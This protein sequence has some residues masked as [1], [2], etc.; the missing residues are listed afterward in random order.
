MEYEILSALNESHKVY[1]VCDKADGKV[2]VQKEL[3]T[4][5]A[6]VYATLAQ[7]PVQ[8]IPRIINIAED[9]SKGILTIIEEYISGNTLDDLIE[10]DGALPEETVISYILAL[11]GILKQLHGFNPPIIHRDITP[12][13]VMLAGDGRLVLL[14][15]N[16][17]KFAEK[18]QSKDTRLLG[19]PGYAAPEQLGFGASAVTTD[20]YAL[21]MLMKALLT[22]DTVLSTPYN[23]YLAP[24][25]R[26]CTDLKPQKRYRNVSLLMKALNRAE[27]LHKNRIWLISGAALIVLAVSVITV[28]FITKQL[29]SLPPQQWDSE[30]IVTPEIDSATEELIIG[31]YKG[32][33]DGGL[34]INP[35]GSAIYYCPSRQYSEVLCPWTFHDNTVTIKLSKLHC[36]ISAEIDENAPGRLNFTSDSRNWNDELFEKLDDPSFSYENMALFAYDDNLLIAEDGGYEFS[37]GSF[38]FHIPRHYTDFPDFTDSDK[39]RYIFIDANADEAYGSQLY[40]FHDDSFDDADLMDDFFQGYA[41]SFAMDFID[42]INITDIKSR[43][44][45]PATLYSCHF[46]G[47]YNKGFNG[48]A[49]SPAAGTIV[50]MYNS[51]TEGVVKIIFSQ[52]SDKNTDLTAEFDDIISNANV[53]KTVQE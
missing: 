28:Y 51:D 23:G 17:G 32:S 25:I 20:I 52:I 9:R 34:T 21:G 44:Q 38:S 40:F 7:Y 12:G 19:T 15:L 10:T 13:N 8:G 33:D 6:S 1:L 30:E 45:G 49:G 4:Y 29:G 48:M 42:S 11:C 31:S 18:G 39:E 24:V 35:D 50:F 5:N 43:T 47:I 2:Y 26:K 27:R 37:V 46:T 16:A 22:A 36:D 53:S 41:S 14:D 3:S